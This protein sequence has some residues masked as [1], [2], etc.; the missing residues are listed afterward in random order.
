MSRTPPPLGPG[1][2]FDIIRRVL[3]DATPPGPEIALGSGD[4]CALIRHGDG[5]LALSV[6]LSVEGGHFVSDWGT[7]ELI[8]ERA[9]RI[10]ISDLAAMSAEP[11][12]TLVSLN[13]PRTAGSGL[14]ERIFR[15]CLAATEACGA[16][17]IGGDLSHA[18]D[19][20]VIDVT[21]LGKVVEPLLRSTARPG[22]ALW[23]TGRL[24]AAAAAVRAWKAGGK[25]KDRWRR[26]FWE[27]PPRIEEARWLARAGASA[28]IDLSDG[29]LADSGHIA[30]ASGIGLEIDWE[31]V[32][33][34]PEIET[35]IALAG[36]EDY[37]LLVA[38]PRDIF[39]DDTTAEFE[40]TFGVPLT[41]VGRAVSGSGVRVFRA[42]QEIEAASPG[43]DHFGDEG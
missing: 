17:H 43:F 6:D 27:P 36:G 13:T 40:L 21:A 23:V 1:G 4:D 38:A 9:V 19:A 30:A 18:A 14:A 24:G 34:A 10:A 28:A 7:P 26:R 2:E 8:G 3:K 33:A 22:D 41:R 37:E 11:L 29:L 35:E 12:A 25:P 5:F 39:T 16:A 15:G 32:P 42:G 31:A 20:I